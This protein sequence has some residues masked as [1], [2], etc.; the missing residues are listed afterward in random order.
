MVSF[1]GT[2][3]SNEN[4]ANK[5]DGSPSMLPAANK[6]SMVQSENQSV[7][8]LLLPRPVSGLLQLPVADE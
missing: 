5:L 4:F 7:L 3:A 1:V 8:V 6:K 2:R